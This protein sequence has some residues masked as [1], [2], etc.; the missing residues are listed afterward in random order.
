M[1]VERVEHADAKSRTAKTI[2]DTDLQILMLLRRSKKTVLIPYNIASLQESA[3]AKVKM[4]YCGW[5]EKRA[6]DSEFEGERELQAA[7]KH[8]RP[9]TLTMLKNS[10][11]SKQSRHIVVILT[12]ISR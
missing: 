2:E 8:W 9:V 10:V 3:T 6:G 11:E 5:E 4:W 12:V 7:C 1:T